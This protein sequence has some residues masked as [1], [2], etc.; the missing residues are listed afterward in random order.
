MPNAKFDVNGLPE[1]K[2]DKGHVLLEEGKP[3][4]KVYV[5]KDGSVAV[6]AGGN[7]LCKVSEAMTMFGEISILLDS[8]ASANVVV[9]E[10]S[11]FYV[12]DDLMKYLT[13]N[14][15]SAIHISQVL[16]KR[17]VEMN[18]VYVQIKTE[19]LKMEGNPAA[20]ASK[21]LWGLILK[22]DA[23]WGREVV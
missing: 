6:V 4:N 8:K 19:V 22:M 10:T 18:K 2:F 3:G 23:F 5:L 9:Q 1:A 11:T 16:A 21:K 15:Q 7:E 12:I 20:K 17:L 14:P 13:T